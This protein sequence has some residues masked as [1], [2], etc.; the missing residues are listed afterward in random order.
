[1]SCEHGLRWYEL[2]PLFSFIG[3]KGRC[4]N[5]KIKISWQYPLV[6]FVS[7]VIFAVLFWKFQGVLYISLKDFISLYTY[8]ALIF[9][10][11]LI[12]V[13][14]D[15]KHKIIPDIL[16]FMFGLLA[17]I[18][19]FVF[20]QNELHFHVP[21]LLDLLSGIFIALP[22]FAFWFFSSGA[23]MGMGDVKL[24]IGLGWLLGLSLA[25]SAITLAFWAGSLVGLYLIFRKGYGMKTEIP[26]APYLVLGTFLAFIFNL[27]LFHIY[28]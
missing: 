4:K 26:F 18:G 20:V 23:W 13:V 16:S 19:L 24:A 9:S 15:L 6:E 5:C 28:F 21:S 17:F 8:Y 12:I 3:L 27:N 2:I 10:I 7:G 14:Y 11:L 1:M 22:F 25:L